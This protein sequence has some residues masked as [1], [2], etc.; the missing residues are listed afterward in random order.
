MFT[1]KARV[2][3][4][5]ERK[6]IF[7]EIKLLNGETIINATLETEAPT[8]SGFIAL[9]EEENRSVKY[10]ALASIISFS[11]TRDDLTLI[12]PEHYLTPTMTI[13]L[14]E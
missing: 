9:I 10:I 13:K 11:M 14:R 12:T 3:E 1:E 8:L 7:T 5:S 4:M 2:S 6:P